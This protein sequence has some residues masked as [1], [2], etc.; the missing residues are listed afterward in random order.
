M[1]RA[2]SWFQ[3]WP[4]ASGVLL[5]IA[6]AIALGWANSGS[7]YH[8]LWDQAL[9]GLPLRWWVNDVLMVVF[10]LLVGLEIKRE[11]RWGRL[12]DARTAALPAPYRSTAAWRV[13][14]RAS[15]KVAPEGS[16]SVNA[17]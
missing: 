2:L 8:A 17:R 13:A 4:P 14:A 10:F 5:L 11:L 12:S 3:H 9:A 16:R 1:R 7:S 6:T 15:E